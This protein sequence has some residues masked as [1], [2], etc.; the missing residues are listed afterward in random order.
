M[1]DT[2]SRP[3]VVI[4]KLLCFYEPYCMATNLQRLQYDCHCSY[5]NI[6]L[7]YNASDNRQHG[8]IFWNCSCHWSKSGYLNKHYG[9]CLISPA[10]GIGLLLIVETI[11]TQSVLLK[12]IL[13]SILCWPQLGCYYGKVDCRT[14][15]HM[16][17]TANK[18]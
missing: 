11:T 15:H 6:Q 2:G 18:A 1:I 4:S 3:R 17:M 5:S 8:L 16:G 7:I 14:I 10:L 12:L 13:G 9:C